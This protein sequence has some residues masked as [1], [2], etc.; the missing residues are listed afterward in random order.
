MRLE[1]DENLN[2]IQGSHGAVKNLL[3]LRQI[4]TEESE[5]IL[6]HCIKTL[7]HLERQLPSLEQRTNLNHCLSYGLCG[8]IDI[9]SDKMGFNIDLMLQFEPPEGEPGSADSPESLEF[10][11]PPFGV[12]EE[13]DAPLQHVQAK[14]CD[15]SEVENVACHLR[16]DI[17]YEYGGGK[18]RYSAKV[19]ATDNSHFFDRK[20][21]WFKTWLLDQVE[22][23][24]IGNSNT[25]VIEC[26]LTSFPS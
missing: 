15:S 19:L 13:T 10:R 20:D 11:L 18:A 5:R 8:H 2:L 17:N 6:D 12:P 4:L 23:S 22:Q 26:L 24:V 21:H 1:L 25:E 14:R 7:H 9:R 3:N 16:F